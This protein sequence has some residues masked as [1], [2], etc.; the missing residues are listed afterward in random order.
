M[1][2]SIKSGLFITC[3]RMLAHHLLQ[4]G[5]RGIFEWHP[6]LLSLYYRLGGAKI[7]KGVTIHLKAQL[8]DFD[9]ISIADNVA[10]DAALV[11]AFSNHDALYFY[12][13]FLAMYVSDIVPDDC[14]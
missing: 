12:G 14:S 10:I 1:L 7:G 9:L 5:G 11:D 6:A 8:T 13:S 4:L 2:L 3:R